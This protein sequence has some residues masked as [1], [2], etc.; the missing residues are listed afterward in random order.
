MSLLTDFVVQAAQPNKP[1]SQSV[2]ATVAAAAGDERAGVLRRYLA[3]QVAQILRTPMHELSLHEPLTYLG[4]D[5]LMALELKNLIDVDL[6]LSVPVTR[7]LEGLS[8]SDLHRL[9]LEKLAESEAVSS[10]QAVQTSAA[11]PLNGRQDAAAMLA[12]LD[13]MS[14]ENIDLLLGQL[15][16]EEG[17]S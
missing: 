16:A 14:E 11:P 9:L 12:Q 17:S 13:A 6:Q 4:I 10:G 3:E 7:L 5:S 1:V 2:R 8:V 15:L